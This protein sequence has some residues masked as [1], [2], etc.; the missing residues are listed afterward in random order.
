MHERTEQCKQPVG[1]DGDGDSYG[2][3]AIVRCD[4]GNVGGEDGHWDTI[5]KMGLGLGGQCDIVM[6]TRWEVC[7]LGLLSVYCDLVLRRRHYETWLD[8]R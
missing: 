3:G 4:T 7:Q 2:D 6:S 8:C 5:G 1:G